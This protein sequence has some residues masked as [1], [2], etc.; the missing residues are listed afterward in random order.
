MRNGNPRHGCARKGHRTPEYSVWNSMMGRCS[1]NPNC[2]SYK[3]YAGRGITVC[4]R[5]KIF[6]NFLADMGKRPSADLTLERINNSKGYSPGNCR[7]A[8]MAE[9]NKN[10]RLRKDHRYATIWRSQ[11]F[12]EWS[13][14]HKYIPAGWVSPANDS[15]DDPNRN[16]D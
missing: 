12:R 11:A 15:K 14:Y 6:E 8:T 1:S 4:G 10:R 13:I 5:W 2:R 9:Q 3:D 7:W 16:A